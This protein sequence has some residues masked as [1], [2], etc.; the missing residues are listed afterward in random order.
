MS[1]DEQMDLDGEEAGKSQK[2]VFQASN[3]DAKGK[4]SAANLPVEA[5]DNLPWYVLHT[6][7]EKCHDLQAL[8]AWTTQQERVRDM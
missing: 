4:R 8:C 7:L 1:E 6:L 5:E 2:I 3:A